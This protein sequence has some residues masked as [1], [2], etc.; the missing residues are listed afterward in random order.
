M[1]TNVLNQCGCVSRE[2]RSGTVVLW[3]ELEGNMADESE[4][5]E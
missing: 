3:E 4:A 2:S 1:S 5:D